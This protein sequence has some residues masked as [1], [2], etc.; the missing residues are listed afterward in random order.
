MSNASLRGCSAIGASTRATKS[1]PATSSAS[2]SSPAFRSSRGVYETHSRAADRRA[3]A[4]WAVPDESPIT[5]PP[6]VLTSCSWPEPPDRNAWIFVTEN[7]SVLSAAADLAQSGTRIRLLCTS[8]TPSDDEVASIARL[9]DAGWRIAVRADFDEAGLA[10]VV[11]LLNGIRA[12]CRGGWA[13]GLRG[14]PRHL[15]RR[16]GA[17][18][19]PES[20]RD[21]VGSAP[22]AINARPRRRVRRSVDNRLARRPF[23]RSATFISAPR[24][25]PIIAWREHLASYSGGVQRAIQKAIKEHAD[26]TPLASAP[27]CAPCLRNSFREKASRSGRPQGNGTALT[28]E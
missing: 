23:A 25:A 5:L 18:P 24:T 15:F 16:L 20:A 17:N 6:R 7:P 26:Y 27:S 9:A 19:H 28:Q 11:T 2:F 8:G 1:S 13:R 12:R 4:S 21:A 10:H 22:V 14:K 3:P